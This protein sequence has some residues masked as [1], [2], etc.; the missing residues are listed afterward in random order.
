MTTINARQVQRYDTAANWASANPLLLAGEIG[1]E[2]DT[3]RIK[4]GDG[5]SL[6]NSLGYL[7]G[8]IG[9]LNDLTDVDLTTTTPQVGSSLVFNAGQWRPGPVLGVQDTSTDDFYNDT[10]FIAHFNGLNDSTIYEDSSKNNLAPA[11]HSSSGSSALSDTHAKFGPT[12]LFLHAI[13]HT[14]NQGITLS[15]GSSE[16]FAIQAIPFTFEFWLYLEP[17]LNRTD[18]IFNNGSTAIRTDGADFCRLTFSHPWASG[19]R[20]Y[21]SGYAIPRGQWVHIAVCRSNTNVSLFAN[22]S[23]IH[24]TNVSLTTI[25]SWGTSFRVGTRAT[26]ATPLNSDNLIGYIDDLRITHNVVR[27]TGETYTVPLVPHGDSLTTSPKIFYTLNAHSDV[28]SNTA[29]TDKQ[30][31][32]WNSSLSKFFAGDVTAKK[33]SSTPAPTTATSTGTSGE[34]RYD[35]DYVYICTATNTWVRTP[36][37]SW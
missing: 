36:L 16:A 33:V 27:Y 18:S 9:S 10:T 7:E 30:T 4:I 32:V 25:T 22:G 31:L 8:Q 24:S 5:N 2:S 34:I 15:A 21:Q 35:A 28:D 17:G 29:P 6:W 11:L 1:V 37:T 20:T 13:G 19:T 23:R 26:T 3:Y 12:S 14:T